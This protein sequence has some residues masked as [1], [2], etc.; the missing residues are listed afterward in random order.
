MSIAAESGVSATGKLLFDHSA[1]SATVQDILQVALAGAG[2]AQAKPA[3]KNDTHAA[4][5]K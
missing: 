4:M 2:T 5:S 3:G 1:T